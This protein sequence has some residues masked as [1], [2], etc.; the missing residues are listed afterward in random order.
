MLSVTINPVPPWLG[1][2]EEG[3][4][5]LHLKSLIDASWSFRLIIHWRDFGVQISTWESS[6]ALL[7]RSRPLLSHLILSMTLLWPCHIFMG[8]LVLACSMFHRYISAPL[9]AASWRSFYQAISMIWPPCLNS[10]RGSFCM[11]LGF[12]ISKFVSSPPD[13]T[14]V[15]V[16]FQQEYIRE[17]CALNRPSS[18]PCWFQTREMLSYADVK[19]R[20]PLWDHCIEE[21]KWSSSALWGTSASLTTLMCLSYIHGDYWFDFW[22]TR[23]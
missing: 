10:Y 2:I 15:S 12:Q 3:S 14:K 9:A 1:L 22:L 5:L 4:L 16:L 18:L 11:V 6:W 7:A 23:L 8:I 19:R 13:A 20:S 21:M 17:F